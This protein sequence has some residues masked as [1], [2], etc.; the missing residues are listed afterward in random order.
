M[1]LDS[2][3]EVNTQWLEPLLAR[4]AEDK[5]HVVVPVIDIISPDTFMYET[6]MLVRGGFNWGMHYRWDPLPKKI[7]ENPSLQTEPIV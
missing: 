4:I 2:H 3:C 6:S 5:K 7:K 1:F